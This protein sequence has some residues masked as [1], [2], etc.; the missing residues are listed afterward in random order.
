MTPIRMP[1]NGVP[2]LVWVG[3]DLWEC[4]GCGRAGQLPR[5]AST[6]ALAKHIGDTKRA[7]AGCGD[8]DPFA[9]GGGEAGI[10]HPLN[11]DRAES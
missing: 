6:A 2:W 9:T 11:P 5:F 1:S 3:R 7:H 8:S 10:G 4:Q